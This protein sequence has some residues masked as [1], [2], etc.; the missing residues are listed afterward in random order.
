MMAPLFP[1]PRRI[2][3]LEEKPIEKTSSS[4]EVQSVSREPVGEIFTTCEPPVV[5]GKSE[6]AGGGCA[7]AAAW[8]ANVT[9]P[10]AVSAGAFA[11]GALNAGGALGVGGRCFSPMAA[12]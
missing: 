11:C 7:A 1:V 8:I 9:A 5:E 12:A 6:K 3:P 2:F 4:R 10:C